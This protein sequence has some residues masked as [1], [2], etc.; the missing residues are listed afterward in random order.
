M[1]RAAGILLF[2]RS[3]DRCLFLLRSDDGTWGVPGGYIERGEHELDAALRELREETGYTG[4]VVVNADAAS[5]RDGYA[6]FVGH[7]SREFRPR[8]DHEHLAAEWARPDAAP[9]P[10]H[11]GLMRVV[12]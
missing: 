8:L 5:V 4:V 6:L 3:T 7:V 1:P 12:G 9:Q 10:L 11:P 2:A